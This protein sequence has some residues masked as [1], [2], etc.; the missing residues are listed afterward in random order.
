MPTYVVLV[1]W[2]EQGRREVGTLV[3]RVAKVREQAE[4]LGVKP[5][6]QL[7]TMGRYDQVVVSEAPDDETMAKVVLM[8]AGQGNAVTE[9]LRGFTVDEVSQ[10]L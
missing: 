10:L 3:D 2:T 5:V 8:V 4:K 1:K 7:V 9:T 6:A